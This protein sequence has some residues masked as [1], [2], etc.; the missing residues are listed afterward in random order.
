ME[1]KFYISRQAHRFWHESTKEFVTEEADEPKDIE[2]EFGCKYV[3]LEGVNEYGKAKNIYTESYAETEE[4]RVYVPEKVLYENTD[5]SLTLVFPCV[6]KNNR[7]DVTT[8]ERIFFEYVSGRC[9][10]WY[11]TFRERYLTLLLINKPEVVGEVLYG[12]MRYREIKYTFKNIYGR[13]FEHSKRGA[14][15]TLDSSELDS[16]DYLE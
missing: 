15:F 9:V 3:K 7:L 6:S 14:V 10:E 11:D 1:Y 2:K 12:D 8:N 4:L 13:S 16:W 5:I